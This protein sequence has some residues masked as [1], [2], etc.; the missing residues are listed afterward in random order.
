MIK[1]LFIL[2]WF[3]TVSAN[4]YIYNDS[5]LLIYAKIIPK[6]M[7]LD[8]TDRRNPP[9]RPIL[10]ILYEKGD[11]ST[12]EKLEKMILANLPGKERKRVGIVSKPY[13][14]TEDCENV[15]AF[16]LLN[17]RADRAKRA[18]DFAKRNHLLSFAYDNNLLA[19]GV[20]VSLHAGKRVYPIVNIDA[21]KQNRLRLDPLL[22]QVAKIYGGGDS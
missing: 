8:H 3:F 10:C 13:T 17:T 15:S 2:Y 19:Y 16:L 4:A 22:F 21:I 5:L 11:R 1:R 6:I 20:I 7:L 9:K 18:I 14:Q 12:A